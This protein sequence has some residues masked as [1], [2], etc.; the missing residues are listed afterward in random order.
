MKLNI[1]QIKKITFG[2]ERIIETENGI[3]FRRMTE[4]TEMGFSE[5]REVFRT[6]SQATAGVRF[7]FYTDSEY[8]KIAYSDVTD[9]APGV[10]Y[11]FDV[12]END[13]L[14]YTHFDRTE[15]NP[16]GEF[17]VNLK[18]ESRVRVFFP[19]LASPEIS[20]VKLSDGATIRSFEP[21]C[22]IV[23]YGDSIT[24]GYYAMC[25]SNSY[26][27]RI[28]DMLDADIR[29][30]GVGAGHFFADAVSEFENFSPDIITVA[31]GTNDWNGDRVLFEPRCENFMERLSEVYG[32]KK[33]F[34]ILPLWRKDYKEIKEKTGDFF[35]HCD[36][37][38]KNA[39]K[40]GFCVIDGLGLMPHDEA[41]CFGDGLHPN[42]AGFAHYAQNL[43]KYIG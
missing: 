24:Q 4:K 17:T 29:N 6:R 2:A 5:Y 25:P 14:I 11:S 8:I 7:D 31:Y 39:E 36:F 1:E 19:N 38:R 27:N 12:Y 30:I 18:K 15:T 40:Y 20:S 35:S 10:F 3:L 37:I 33:V 32:D 28:S 16:S 41:L 13:R 22:S 23:C 34:I 43:L 9:G 21:A 26:V 42:D